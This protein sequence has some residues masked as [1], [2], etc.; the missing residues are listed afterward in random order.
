MTVC[1]YTLFVLDYEYILD[2]YKYIL[3]LTCLFYMMM[4]LEAG[5]P[6]A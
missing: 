4:Y 6:D 2:D 1:P 3:D 5:Q